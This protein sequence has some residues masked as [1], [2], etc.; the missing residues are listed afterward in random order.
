MKL[1]LLLLLGIGIGCGKS[2]RE[3]QFEIERAAQLDHLHRTEAETEWYLH[4]TDLNNTAATRM[5]E[6]ISEIF[7]AGHGKGP[8]CQDACLKYAAIIQAEHD[9]PDLFAALHK[10]PMTMPTTRVCKLERKP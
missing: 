9:R 1:A 5:Y 6:C 4:F 3:K 2:Q 10:P 7:I 8:V